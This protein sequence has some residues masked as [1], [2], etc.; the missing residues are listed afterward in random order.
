MAADNE[1][2][3]DANELDD[4]LDTSGEG[5]ADQDSGEN[6]NEDD[7]AGD[8]SEDS[9]ES[10]DED[11]SGEGDGEA[12]GDGESG[13]A[14]E[15]EDADSGETDPTE[16][17]AK[18]NRE[19]RQV[20]REVK[21]EQAMTAA[22]LKRLEE[23]AVARNDE[24]LDEE[25][26][27]TPANI[28]VLQDQLNNINATKGPVLDTLLETMKMNPTYSDIEEVCSKANFADIFDAVAVQIAADEGISKEEAAIKAEIEVW[29]LANPYKEMYNIIKTHH[30]DYAGKA[31]EKEEKEDKKSVAK[32]DKGVKKK[33]PSNAPG[34]IN[35]MGGTDSKQSS[36]WTAKR[37]DE[38]DETDDDFNR[39]PHDVYM[40]YLSGDLD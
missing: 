30:P 24:D 35:N 29:S 1:G 27:V 32:P 33:T 8:D 16:Q 20:M 12:D 7:E 23:E 19:L 31:E 38:M 37:I 13:D 3:Q 28:E 2:V 36:E 5:D 25:R 14:D 34:S 11:S 10:G 39:I 22:K 40:K 18:E 26:Q 17:L 9:D 21:R 15:S 6:E 4:A